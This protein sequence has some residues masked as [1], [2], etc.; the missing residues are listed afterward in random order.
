MGNSVAE[1]PLAVS[2]LDLLMVLGEAANAEARWEG[3]RSGYWISS[4]PHKAIGEIMV[5]TLSMSSAPST[6]LPRPHIAHSQDP[7]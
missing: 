7:L 5:V 1:Y 2:D 6:H 4:S 3:L